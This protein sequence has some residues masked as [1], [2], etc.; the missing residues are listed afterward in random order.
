MVYQIVGNIVRQ[1]FQQGARGLY[2]AINFQD[3][4]ID[5]AWSAARFN[6][7]IRRGVR[8]GAGI[9]AATGYFISNEFQDDI[10]DFGFTTPRKLPQTRYND[11]TRR[12]QTR[13]PSRCIPYSGKY[14]FR[15]RQPFTYR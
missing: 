10:E 9:G 5:K 11:K 2:R 6:R 1:I 4:A 7:N 8:H 14:S 15:K 3:K 12:R 13:R